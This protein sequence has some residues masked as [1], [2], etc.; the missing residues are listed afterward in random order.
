ML[1]N[2]LQLPVSLGATDSVDA[3]RNSL[4][5]E[6]KIIISMEHSVLRVY[7]AVH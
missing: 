4:Y 7:L 1:Q 5:L 2:R 3:C 6:E